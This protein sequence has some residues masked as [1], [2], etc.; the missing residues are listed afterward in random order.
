MWNRPWPIYWKC[1]LRKTTPAMHLSHIWTGR[2]FFQETLIGQP[3]HID[4]DQSSEKVNTQE[5]DLER[6][7]PWLMRFM[8]RKKDKYRD[9]DSGKNFLTASSTL[10]RDSF[11]CILLS[12]SYNGDPRYNIRYFFLEIW[13][14]TLPFQKRQWPLW[15]YWHLSLLYIR[16]INMISWY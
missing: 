8:N 9:S 14:K 12:L 5:S 2:A 1:N 11:L 3:C 13:D 6:F 16:S 7:W 10:R 15:L 4:S